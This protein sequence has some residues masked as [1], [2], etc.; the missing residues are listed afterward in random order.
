ML[1]EKQIHERNTI[2]PVLD[3]AAAGRFIKH[4]LHDRSGRKIQEET[5]VE[6]QTKKSYDS[7]VNETEEKSDEP[8]NKRIKFNDDND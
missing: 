8:L 1:R 5:N 2:R 4:G 6:E 7:S 3:K